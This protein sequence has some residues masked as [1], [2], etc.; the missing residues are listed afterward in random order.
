[1]RRAFASTIQIHKLQ[2]ALFDQSITE[3]ANYLAITFYIRQL[4]PPCTFYSN[5]ILPTKKKS[6]DASCSN[7]YANE[8]PMPT[9]YLCRCNTYANAIPM[10]PMQY[11]CCRRN[12][13]ANAMPNNS[14][15]MA[16][17]QPYACGN[18]IAGGSCDC[19]SRSL[20]Y[21]S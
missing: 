16:T 9:K 6:E 8:I 11:I 10:L 19:V 12:T 20:G 7:T 18:A 1:M 3:K 2:N 17:Q 21:H 13:Y 4:A 14:T 5:L 15:P